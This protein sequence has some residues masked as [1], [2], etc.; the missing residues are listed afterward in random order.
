FRAAMPAPGEEGSTLESRLEG[1]EGRVRAKTGT[2]S[3]VNSLSGYIVRGTGEEVA[4]SILSNGSGMPA[5][6]VRS[7]I[8]EIVRALAR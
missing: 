7:A 2:I 3:N 4:F 1:L 6:R 8:D 5:S